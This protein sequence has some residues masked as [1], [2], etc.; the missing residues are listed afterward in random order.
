RGA[1]LPAARPQLRIDRRTGPRD[2][3]LS[4]ERPLGIGGAFPRSGPARP[5]AGLRDA[6]AAGAHQRV[7]GG[8]GVTRLPAS[9][10]PILGCPRGPIASVV[11]C[12]SDAPWPKT[13]RL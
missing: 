5:A 4:P 10:D 1:R 11:P 12:I 2:L 8:A 7:E 6:P 13:G 9:A 3:R